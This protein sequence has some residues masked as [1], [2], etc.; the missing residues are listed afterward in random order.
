[1]TL[2]NMTGMT[3]GSY[4][5]F[6]KSQLITCNFVKACNGVCPFEDAL[7]HADKEM[8]EQTVIDHDR[9]WIIGCIKHDG[10][11]KTDRF[12]KA[13]QIIL[14]ALSADT[15]SREEYEEV[16][17]YMDT[18]VDAFIE[19]GEEL[20]ESVKVVRCKDCKHRPHLENENG[21]DYGFNVSGD[22]MCPCVNNDD[23]WY[24]WMPKDNFYCG[25]GERK[26]G[27]TE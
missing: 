22:E 19:D 6:C 5:G 14:D 10:F 24:S 11:I 2:D 25:F 13:N 17:A 12:D 26:G 16:K 4:T 9:D 15:V 3:E 27:D 23:G 7:K 8:N 21:S 18:L 1:M 20:A